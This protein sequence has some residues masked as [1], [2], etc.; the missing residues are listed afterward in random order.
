MY[1]LNRSNIY[2]ISNEILAL[3]YELW[4]FFAVNKI[5]LINFFFFNLLSKRMSI[6]NGL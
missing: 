6:I 1:T 2:S 3:R 5:K 4:F